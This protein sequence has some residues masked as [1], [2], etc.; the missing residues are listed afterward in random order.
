MTQPHVSEPELVVL[1][2]MRCMGFGGEARIA[3]A[4]GVET[5][6]VVATSAPSLKTVSFLTT[7]DRLAGGL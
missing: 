1:H 2:A 3:I 5:A 6:D 7:M 4:A